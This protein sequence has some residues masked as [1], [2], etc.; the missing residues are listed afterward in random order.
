MAAAAAAAVAVAD[1][2]RYVCIAAAAAL[3]TNF[4]HLIGSISIFNLLFFH[5][6]HI[7]HY[8]TYF[9]SVFSISFHYLTYISSI[10]SVSFHY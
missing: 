9:S 10:I 1:D 6:I 5:N 8:S 2:L 7:F 4:C 3:D